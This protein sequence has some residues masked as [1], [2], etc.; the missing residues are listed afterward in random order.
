M[1]YLWT[2]SSVPLVFGAFDDGHPLCSTLICEGRQAVPPLLDVM[3]SRLEQRPDLCEVVIVEVRAPLYLERW[4]HEDPGAS[5]VVRDLNTDVTRRG[6]A[7]DDKLVAF[8]IAQRT[9]AIEF[10]VMLASRFARIPRDAEVQEPI[11]R[12][13]LGSKNAEPMREVLHAHWVHWMRLKVELRWGFL[14]DVMPRPFPT[15]DWA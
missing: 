14:E 10:V 4:V 13:E 6:R 12:W 2:L 8:R 7:G 1:G 15:A 11:I 9:H 5:I 3:L